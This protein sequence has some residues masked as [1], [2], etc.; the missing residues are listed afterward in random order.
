LERDSYAA[1]RDLRGVLLAL[2]HEVIQYFQEN[3]YNYCHFR[4]MIKS[5]ENM[6]C[7]SKWELTANDLAAAADLRAVDVKQNVDQ[8]PRAPRRPAKSC[9]K[10][11]RHQH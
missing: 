2:P 1:L 6:S 9:E 8:R 11:R 5:K 7:S 10:K 4:K 3:N